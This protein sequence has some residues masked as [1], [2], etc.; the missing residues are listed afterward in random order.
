M[1]VAF[2]DLARVEQM[3]KIRVLRGVLQDFKQVK[4]EASRVSQFLDTKRASDPQNKIVSKVKGL[5]ECPPDYRS[6]ELM[7]AKT[8][9]VEDLISFDI[10]RIKGG[11]MAFQKEMDT[12]RDKQLARVGQLTG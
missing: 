5:I 9:G 6:F 2:H 11:S 10:N 4:K 1:K 8:K 7:Q 3:K 12:E